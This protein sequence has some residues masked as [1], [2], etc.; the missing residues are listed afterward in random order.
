MDKFAKFYETEEKQA[1][2]S[3]YVHLNFKLIHTKMI[4]ELRRK[5]DI[6][7]A[8]SNE[9]GYLSL[10][11]SLNARMF[12]E[13]IYSMCA[14]CQSVN[15]KASEIIPIA[16]IQIFLDLL[17][18]KNALGGRIRTDVKNDLEGFKEYYTKHIDELRKVVEA[19]P[20]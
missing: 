6:D 9:E 17:E 19:L 15:M 16:T 5:L 10:L 7:P 2:L 13:L 11:V 14:I 1:E 8:M 20:K 12:D 18:G 3:E 4:S